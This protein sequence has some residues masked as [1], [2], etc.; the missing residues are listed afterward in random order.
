MQG[1]KLEKLDISGSQLAK[2]INVGRNAIKRS[3]EARKVFKSL[4]ML[5]GKE[6]TVGFE[7]D[8]SLNTETSTGLP[9]KYGK[10]E[11]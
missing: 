4:K 5:N 9:K 10:L 6:L 7:L 2:E 1:W 3:K 11:M 8:D